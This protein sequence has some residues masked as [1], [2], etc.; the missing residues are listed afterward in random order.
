MSFLSCR[1]L[2]DEGKY[3]ILVGACGFA[4]WSMGASGLLLGDRGEMYNDAVFHLSSL[5]AD[6]TSKVSCRHHA[7]IRG[8]YCT[9][10]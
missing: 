3:H 4:S 5:Q 1:V 8:T 10:F 2:I 9:R 7:G 6:A